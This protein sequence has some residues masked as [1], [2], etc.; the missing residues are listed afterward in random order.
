MGDLIFLPALLTGPLGR[1]FAPRKKK[2]ASQAPSPAGT[3]PGE[4]A[5]DE[6][7]LDEAAEDKTAAA[8]AKSKATTLHLRKDPVHRSPRTA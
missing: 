4:A 7:A 6:A 8:A 5:L 1:V 3:L 2:R